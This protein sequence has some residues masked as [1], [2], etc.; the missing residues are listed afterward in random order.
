MSARAQ[1]PAGILYFRVG[2][3]LIGLRSVVA[4]VLGIFL[5]RHHKGVRCRVCYRPGRHDHCYGRPDVPRRVPC[6][7]DARIH[8]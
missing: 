3:F 8:D 6:L 1:R 5:A 7:T 2:F 4:M